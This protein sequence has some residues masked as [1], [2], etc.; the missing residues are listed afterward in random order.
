[1]L[2]VSRKAGESLII[3]DNIKITLLS[4]GADKVSIG[5]E[6]PRTV[7]VIRGELLETIEANKESAGAETVQAYGD[8]AAFVKS[9]K[10]ENIAKEND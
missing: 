1:M 9:K 5:I 8:I 2:V 3:S 6:A 4:V 7:K 10:P